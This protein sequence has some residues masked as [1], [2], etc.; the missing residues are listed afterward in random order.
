V[1]RSM[2]TTSVVV[3]LACQRDQAA[4]F[5]NRRESL[6]ADTVLRRGGC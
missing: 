2:V 3:L 5:S 4:K 1:L 6:N